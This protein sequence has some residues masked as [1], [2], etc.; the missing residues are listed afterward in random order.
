M[1]VGI[2]KDEGG[3]DGGGRIEEEEV[4]LAVIMTTTEI[5]HIFH[6]ISLFNLRVEQRVELPEVTSPEV[7]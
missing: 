5:F 1:Q 3:R 4:S 2:T 6:I 7:T